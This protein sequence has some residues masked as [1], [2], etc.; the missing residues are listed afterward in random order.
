MA[1]RNPHFREYLLNL[2]LVQVIVR[3]DKGTDVFYVRGLSPL[4][5]ISRGHSIHLYVVGVYIARYTIRCYSVFWVYKIA[6]LVVTVT[7]SYA[8]SKVV[9]FV[10]VP[11]IHVTAF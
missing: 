4:F 5:M 11:E 9:T 2:L 7:F 10:Y 1:H 8:R 6:V 3:V